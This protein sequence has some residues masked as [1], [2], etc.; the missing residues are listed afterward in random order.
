MG[1]LIGVE[2]RKKNR[3]K[4]TMPKQRFF[5]YTHRFKMGKGAKKNRIMPWKPLLAIVVC[6]MCHLN[7]VDAL[8]LANV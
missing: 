4:T 5:C 6:I 2:K 8:A 7:G 1:K 3:E